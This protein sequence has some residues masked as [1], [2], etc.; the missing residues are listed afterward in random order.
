[1]TE[2]YINQKLN[3][4]VEL[5]FDDMQSNPLED[6]DDSIKFFIESRSVVDDL[7]DNLF[8]GDSEA[9]QAEHDRYNNASDLFKGLNKIA[10]NQGMLIYPITKYEH[11]LVNYYLGTDEGWD[12]GTAGFVLVDVKQAKE[13]YGFTNKA[14]IE[15]YLNNVLEAYTDYANGDVYCATIYELNSKGEKEAELDYYGDIPADNANIKGL[16]D[17]GLLDGELKDWKEAKEQVKTSY[18]LAQIAIGIICQNGII[19]VLT[20][21]QALAFSPGKVK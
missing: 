7:I 5:D 1:M 12:C 6:L 21:S 20:L 15:S 8:D 4:L 11:S 19:N 2:L 16:F 18:T 17:L 10:K 13:N 3:Q 14:N 9:Y